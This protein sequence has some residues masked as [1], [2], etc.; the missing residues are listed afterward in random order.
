MRKYTALI[1]LQDNDCILDLNRDCKITVAPKGTAKITTASNWS[2]LFLYKT[3]YS[4]FSV[5]YL[6]KNKR[7]TCHDLHCG[8]L[9]NIYITTVYINEVFSVRKRS[10]PCFFFFLQRL[11]GVLHEVLCIDG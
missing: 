7:M 4:G 5:N 10:S 11:T 1:N 8:I 6:Q 9:Y 2:F 3:N